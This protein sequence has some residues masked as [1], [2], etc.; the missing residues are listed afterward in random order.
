MQPVSKSQDDCDGSEV[1]MSTI[2]R[3]ILEKFFEELESIDGFEDTAANL[4]NAVL[5]KPNFSENSVRRAIFG[6]NTQ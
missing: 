4:K 5:N 3:S 2:S 1:V 6:D